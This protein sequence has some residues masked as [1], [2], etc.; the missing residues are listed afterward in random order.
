M[1]K[2]L[3]AWWVIWCLGSCASYYQANY[4]FNEEFEKGDLE[5]ALKT[6][7]SH[8]S[9]GSGKRQF[10][11]EVNNGLLLSMMGRYEESNQYLEKA[12]LYG[13]DY[14]IN[15]LNEIGSYL[16]N[17]NFVSYKGEDHEHLLLLYY[18]ALNYLKLGNKEDALVECRRLNIRE[19]QL[20]DRYASETKF[21]DDAFIHTLMGIIYEADHDYNNAFIAYRK[22]L[23]VYEDEYR[24]L[25]D[26]G[27]PG[28]LK[29]DILRTAHLS[30]MDDEM[31]KY[32]EQFGMDDYKYQPNNAG[33]L[34]FFWH[35][36]LSPVK[37]EW[38]VTFVVS[39][40]GGVV[41]FNNDQLG[42]S[43]PFQISGLNEKQVQGLATMGAMRVAF[44]KY[45]ERPQYYNSATLSSDSLQYPLMLLEDVNKVAFKCL[46]ERMGLEFSKAL[47]RVAIKKLEEYEVRKQDAT[48]GAVLSIINAITEK[49]DTRNWQTLPHSIFYARVPLK[50]GLN[51]FTLDV[52]DVHGRVQHHEFT[53]E[54][55]MGET[56]FH[57]FTNLESLY[58]SYGYN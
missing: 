58:P 32:K 14:R 6:L 54:G 40:Q 47:L 28:Q 57:T 13:E 45:V 43:F 33:E 2:V 56:R 52:T 1:K 12:Y 8:S 49:A 10:L 50:V 11:Y 17:P 41:F 48:A 35:N 26:L 46:E 4:T 23:E 51:R 29:V 55:K 31:E 27:P 44:P 19:Q 39:R 22:A 9:E 24:K 18:K 21:R 42:M 3:L 7:R 37:V 16:T 30:G 53:Y 20:T 15:Y 36:G 38:G 25:F 34:V 5:K